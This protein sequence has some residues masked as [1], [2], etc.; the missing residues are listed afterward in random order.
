[1]KVVFLVV[2]VGTLVAS[3]ATPLSSRAK[4]QKQTRK[5]RALPQPSPTPSPLSTNP[6]N[7]SDST[8]REDADPWEER[9]IKSVSDA[10]QIFE[11]VDGS[12]YRMLRDYTDRWHEYNQLNISQ[13][14]ERQWRREMITKLSDRLLNPATDAEELENL[15]FRLKMMCGAQDDTESVLKIYEVTRRIVDRL[16]LEDG[17][18]VSLYISG[19]WPYSIINGRAYHSHQR[20]GL[21]YLA[22]RHELKDVAQDLADYSLS[23]ARRAKSGEVDV[24]RAKDAIEAC[25]A[26]KRHFRLR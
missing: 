14:Q 8:S 18:S 4:P 1:M 2:V 21:I 24:E 25:L 6:T 16:P 10:R 11:A 5:T 26:V 23:L 19:N 13:A 20:T 9:S 7:T 17:V 12:G 15:Y 3:V 22:M